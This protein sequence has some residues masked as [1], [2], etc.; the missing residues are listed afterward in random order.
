M[1][2]RQ[3]VDRMTEKVKVGTGT[4]VDLAEA[5]YRLQGLEADMAK[6]DLDVEIV[7]RQ[8]Q[9]LTQKPAR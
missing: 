1:V 3:Q 8:L 9:Q 6:A 4:R 5:T 7:R 2:A